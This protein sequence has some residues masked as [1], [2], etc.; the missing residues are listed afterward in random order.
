[1]N[2]LGYEG[3]ESQAIA[4]L[5]V[6]RMGGGADTVA[7]TYPTYR[8]LFEQAF[9]DWPDNERVTDETAGLAIAA[10]ERTLV[11]NEAPFQQWLR[12]EVDALTAAEKRGAI[13]FF[14]EGG[15]AT[16][17]AGPALG[18]A[19]FHALGM[20]DLGGL[21]FI[22]TPDPTDPVHFG[23]GG[24]TGQHEDLYRFKTPQLYNLADHSAFGHGATFATVREVVAYKNDAVPQ[25]P[26][27]PADRL[28][29]SFRPL[30]LSPAALDDLTAF[31][32]HGL[33]DPTLARYTPRALPSGHCFPNN[34]AQ[35]RR[36]LRCTTA[37]DSSPEQ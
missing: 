9:P 20:G 17:H 37:S 2:R 33:Y 8:R 7:A 34:D 26:H 6:H 3:L 30:K 13:T 4:A 16:C 22:G 28:S 1:V 5:N 12:G 14:G 23:R 25:N 18:S 24:F 10:F 15:C 29:P 32:E 27:V 11:A 35:S 19:T 21:D 31:L 36:D